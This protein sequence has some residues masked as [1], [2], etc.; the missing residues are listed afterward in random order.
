MS[1]NLNNIFI[2]GDVHGCYYTLLKLVKKLPDNAELVFL[3]DL[4]D[5]GKHS[6][7]VIEFVMVNDY[8]CVK[9]NHE[10]FYEKNMINAMEKNISSIW[11]K[12]KKYGGPQCIESYNGD[13][14]TMHRHLHWIK[15]LPLYL[16]IGKY[17]ITHGFALEYFDKKDNKLYSKKL[18]SNR[19]YENTIEPDV[20][21]DIV[22]IFGHCCFENVKI[23][24]K[25]ICIDTGCYQNGR[26]TAL[27]LGTHKLY[28]EEMDIR[29]A[30]FHY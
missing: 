4:C 12:E 21:P 30:S 3:G 25:Y 23:G 18:F 11:S 13:F 6:Q 28:S 2:I 26:L 16:Q 22:N 29:D 5:K 1:R 19:C 24:K 7:Q 27:S 8:Q 14:K 15:E 20:D 17:F 9:G 10:Y